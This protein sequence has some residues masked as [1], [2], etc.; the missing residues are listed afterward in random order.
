MSLDELTGQLREKGIVLQRAGGNLRF[1]A[2][3]APPGDELAAVREHKVALVMQLLIAE[4][5]EH[6]R[7][8]QIPR[9]LSLTWRRHLDAMKGAIALA[10]EAYDRRDLDDLRNALDMF[11]AAA[12]RAIQEAA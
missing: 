6:V 5:S 8:L 3:Y 1:P 12:R 7:H 4:V 2:N 11:S 10:E 9:Q